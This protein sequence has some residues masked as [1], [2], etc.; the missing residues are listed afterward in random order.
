MIRLLIAEDDELVRAGLSA[1]VGSAPD[2]DVVA[3][4]GDGVDAI[5]LAREHTPDAALLDIGMPKLSGI[6]AARQI[7]HQHPDCAVILLTTLD[8]DEHVHAALEFEHSFVLKASSPTELI[9]A[10][11]I[12]ASG[13]SYIAP[14]ITARLL[15][16][17]LTRQPGVTTGIDDLTD[18]ERDVLQQLAHG[19]SNHGIG[20]QLH[21]SEGTVK[22]HVK[23]ILR[24]LGVDNRVK[25]A[26]I[27]H[28]AGLS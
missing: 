21:L 24:K 19:E 23:A 1:I 17:T 15:E 5:R 6:D 28:R 10:V 20:R 3:Q 13:G 4:A 27:A 2:I 18:R 25:A 8:R 9:H 22:V 16:R 7:T 14:R 11:R 26:I 12:A